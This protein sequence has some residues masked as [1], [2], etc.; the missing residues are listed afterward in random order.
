MKKINWFY[1][2][3]LLALMIA[4]YSF[5]AQV[6][7]ESDITSGR[8]CRFVARHLISGF[9]GFE[10]SVQKQIVEGMSFYV[11]KAAHFSEYALM[12]FL[13]Y[14]WLHRVKFAPLI[15]LAATALY[16]CTDEF[17][18]LFVPGRAGQLRDV[19]IDSSGA[20]FGI[21]VAFVLI[22][23]V[24]CVRRREIVCWGTWSVPD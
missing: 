22:C 23:I 10:S 14:L 9:S 21:L 16:S 4:I 2:L 19:L 17:H 3:L 6:A 18:Q 15:A 13:W 24:Y 5:S 20:V 1:P 12:G 11:R 8:V 7:D